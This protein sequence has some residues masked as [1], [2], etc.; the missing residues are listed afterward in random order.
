MSVAEG[1]VQRAPLLCE[2]WSPAFMPPGRSA[3]NVQSIVRLDDGTLVAFAVGI[4]GS[5]GWLSNAIVVSSNEGWTSI[6]RTDSPDT[7]VHLLPSG[8]VAITGSFRT[9]DDEPYNGIALWNGTAFERLGDG[10]ETQVWAVTELS[11]GRIVAGGGTI[12][13][14]RHRTFTAGGLQIWDGT[15]WD[16]LLSNAY[17]RGLAAMDDGTFLASYS[18]GI[19]WGRTWHLDR[20][21]TDGSVLEE[22]GAFEATDI[23]VGPNNELFAIKP[24]D[25][26]EW[27]GQILR[28]KDDVWR[29]EYPDGRGRLD[30]SGEMLRVVLMESGVSNQVVRPAGDSWA[31]IAAPMVGTVHGFHVSSDG[32]LFL[33]GDPLRTPTD[34]AASVAEWSGSEWLPRSVNVPHL[35]VEILT[36]YST[37][38]PTLVRPMP[39]G[40][41]VVSGLFNGAGGVEARNIAVFKGDHWEALG[42]GIEN[43][44]QSIFVD[45]NQDLYVRPRDGFSN[46][47][48]VREHAVHWN[49][50]E[51]SEVAGSRSDSLDFLDFRRS[52]GGV[53]F[54]VGR[55]LEPDG[56][57]RAALFRKDGDDWRTLGIAS[58]DEASDIG[59]LVALPDGS[60]ILAGSFQAFGDVHS[61]GIVRYR[62]GQFDALPNL[63]WEGATEESAGRIS[64]L[65]VWGNRAWVMA[66]VQL[67]NEGRPA[68]MASLEGDAWQYYG[69]G[70]SL[71]ASDI[72]VGADGRMYIVGDFQWADQAH[73]WGLA[74]WT[75]TTWEAVMEGTEQ[76]YLKTVTADA[77]G[78]V[79]VGTRSSSNGMDYS[80]SGFTY[81]TPPHASIP[82]PDPDP[83]TPSTSANEIQVFPNPASHFVTV[84]RRASG[85]AI[86]AVHDVLGRRVSRFETSDALVSM[87]VS[88]LV[89]GVYFVRVETQE[90]TSMMRF[91][92]RR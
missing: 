59:H 10:F 85:P 30:G 32:S 68:R 1:C 67:L 29:V 60:L 3:E 16:V 64:E 19:A 62:A 56:T 58:H 92:V 34:A 15:Q 33:A 23:G 70:T 18:F 12:N 6:G 52:A 50:V 44:A 76:R 71:W 28:R 41:V 43:A 80:S 39:G 91:I 73:A 66:N 9:I 84:A 86:V 69:P 14:G 77:S 37:N 55:I 36:S 79:Y 49:G 48:V 46:R 27:N 22:I 83:E 47:E 5:S 81:W 87:D 57:W 90:S 17:V 20:M 88:S 21:S 24:W 2:G 25:D 4:H 63:E 13:W 11:D 8:R 74:R 75:G 7:K 53:L 40:G 45:W 82:D 42:T 54:G 35:G 51:W 61:P 89:S 78:R 38:T 72:S 65:I 31:E 26:P